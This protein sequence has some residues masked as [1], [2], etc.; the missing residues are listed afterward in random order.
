MDVG[1]GR[2][3]RELDGFSCRELP[4][5]RA[6]RDQRPNLSFPMSSVD[7]GNRVRVRLQDSTFAFSVLMVFAGLLD[8]SAN[9]RWQYRCGIDAGGA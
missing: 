9:N 4:A 1:R 7:R 8:L 2:D 3:A 5:P 6:A